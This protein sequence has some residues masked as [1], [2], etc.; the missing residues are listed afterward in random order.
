MRVG[1]RGERYV[2]KDLARGVHGRHEGNENREK[3]IEDMLRTWIVRERNS[4][5]L[6]TE[7]YRSLRDA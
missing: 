6:S 1:R 3:E 4:G 7:T 2:L 5:R